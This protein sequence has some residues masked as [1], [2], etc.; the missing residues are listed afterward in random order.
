MIIFMQKK[1]E[2]DL[3]IGL[4]DKRL[5]FIESVKYLGVKIYINF[6]CQYHINDLN[7]TIRFTFD[8]QN[9]RKNES[10]TPKNIF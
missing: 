8:L 3:K 7:T 10:S 6:S 5:Y 4:C 1:C 9:L 2:G